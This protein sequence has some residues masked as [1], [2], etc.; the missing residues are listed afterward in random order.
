[1]RGGQEYLVDGGVVFLSISSQ[2]G[3]DRIQNLT[4]DVPGFVWEGTV[5]SS[6]LVP[7]DLGRADLLSCLET[8][9]REEMRGGLEYD[10]RDPEEQARSISAQAA[11][12][13]FHQTGRSLLSKWET[14][15]FRFNC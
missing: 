7:F 2:Y 13:Q 1:M 6:E 15:L 10:F 9:A 12:A 3:Q 14:H 8:Y 11:L 4:R 5:A